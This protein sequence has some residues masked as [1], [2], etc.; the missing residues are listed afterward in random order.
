MDVKRVKQILSS[1]SRIDVTYHGVP[2]WIESCDEGRGI[3]NV[4]DVETP[5]ET[6][7][8]DVTSLEEQ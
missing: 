6:V 3:A 5:N 7:Q 1:S 4:H 8:V 2:V